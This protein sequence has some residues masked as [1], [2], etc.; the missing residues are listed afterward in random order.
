M[1]YLWFRTDAAEGGHKNH[2]GTHPWAV[3][4]DSGDRFYVRAVHSVERGAT[5]QDGQARG[6][7]VNHVLRFDEDRMVLIEPLPVL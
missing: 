7:P 2:R 5:V 1:A 3:E 6:L 4:L